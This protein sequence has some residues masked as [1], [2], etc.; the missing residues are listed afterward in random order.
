MGFVSQFLNIASLCLKASNEIVTGAWNFSTAPTLNTPIISNLSSMNHTH[1]SAAQGGTIAHT[2]L[3]SIGTNT[4]AQIDTHI[5]ATAA[6]GISGAVVGTTDTQSLSNKTFTGL[7]SGDEA[8]FHWPTTFAWVKDDFSGN[9]NNAG[10]LTWT[11]IASG[12]GAAVANSSGS[13][14]HPGVRRCSSG[15]ITTSYAGMTWRTAFNYPNGGDVNV[16]IL[17]ISA[18][19]GI[20]L[21]FGMYDITSSADSNDGYYFE[22]DPSVSANWQM[23]T[24]NSGSRTKTPTSIAVTASTWYKLEIRVNNANSSAEYF[25]NDASAGTMTLTLPSGSGDSFGLGLLVHNN[26]GASA[27]VDVDVDLMYWYNKTLVR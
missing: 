18:I 22:F 9:S 23:V 24:A 14:N 20:I 10:E 27:N 4:H 21:R 25:I 1:A 12:T 11:N 8:N 26:G 16:W 13:L 19:T 2:A 5:A 6:H 17:Q 7:T 3:T 15:T